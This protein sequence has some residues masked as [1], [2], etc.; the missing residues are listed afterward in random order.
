MAHML[1]YP[2]VKPPK[3]IVLVGPPGCG[4]S[5]F[6]T[7]LTLLLGQENVS[8]TTTLRMGRLEGNTLIHVDKCDLHEE[9]GQ[10]YGLLTTQTVA[11]TTSPDQDPDT[12]PSQHRVLITINNMSPLLNHSIAFQQRFIVIPCGCTQDP[13][14]FHAAMHDPLQIE[15][16]CQVLM[17]R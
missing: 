3:G 11:V 9:L 16:F 1:Q 15:A 12:F 7:F 8:R 5:L 14:A 4:K 17:K 13:A 6:A 2:S 10:I